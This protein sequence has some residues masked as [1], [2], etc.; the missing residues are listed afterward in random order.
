MYDE[1]IVSTYWEFS[2]DL[3]EEIFD[4]I[5]NEPA[6]FRFRIIFIIVHNSRDIIAQLFV[7]RKIKRYKALIRTVAHRWNFRCAKFFWKKDE[8]LFFPTVI[9]GRNVFSTVITS[10]NL[11][12]TV[13]TNG[14]VFPTVISDGNVFLTVISSSNVFS[15][16]TTSG[17]VFTT[18][19]TSG[20]VFPTVITSRNN[21][22]W[23]DAATCFIET[24]IRRSRTKQNIVSSTRT[25]WDTVRCFISCSVM[26]VNICSLRTSMIWQTF[27][28]M[29]CFYQ[30]ICLSW[31][32]DDTK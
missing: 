16:V 3:L 17:N 23:A 27:Q 32:F 24:V 26:C 14:N 12:L 1:K 18:V 8:P 11:F 13:I 2:E 21:C 10:G 5:G 25:W 7:L 4:T 28:F 29:C 20:N 22:A 31:K 9:S 15:T 19:I 6:L 30:W